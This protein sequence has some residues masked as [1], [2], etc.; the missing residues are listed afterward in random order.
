[1]TEGTCP[2][3]GNHIGVAV[4]QHARYCELR[5]QPPQHNPD[6]G[7]ACLC[8]TCVQSREEVLR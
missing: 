2:H 3:C 1:M 7:E 5:P 8:A 6:A 4:A